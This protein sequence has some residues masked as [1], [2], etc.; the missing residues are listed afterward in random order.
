[1]PCPLPTVRASLGASSLT[2]LT[3]AL[4]LGGCL[5]DPQAK[6]CAE[7]PPGS[8]GCPADGGPLA[9]AAQDTADGGPDAA[10]DAAPDDD[11]GPADAAPG[12]MGGDDMAG[13]DMAG[14]DMGGGE[15]APGTDRPC[16]SDEGACVAGRQYCGPDGRYAECVGQT[17]PADEAC[18]GLDD[19]CD[20]TTDEG[21]D[22]VDGSTQPCGSDVGACMPGEQTCVGGAWSACEGAVDGSE[23]ICDAADNDCDGTA[24]EVPAVV[25]MRPC[26][27]GTG[28]CAA[29]GVLVCAPGTIGAPSCSAVEGAP[30]AESCNGQDDDC[31]EATDEDI[32]SRS[33]RLLAGEEVETVP[34]AIAP[35]GEFHGVA[36]IDDG[37]VFFGLALGDEWEAGPVEVGGYDGGDSGG[38]YLALSRTADGFRIAVSSW[39]VGSGSLNVFHLSPGGENLRRQSIWNSQSDG[40]DIAHRDGFGY[41]IAFE[42][43][44]GGAANTRDIAIDVV[45]DDVARMTTRYTVPGD[46][47]H[48]RQPSVAWA[49]DD[50]AVAAINSDPRN[51]SG[52]LQLSVFSGLGGVPRTTVVERSGSARNPSLIWLPQHQ[53]LALA[54]DT[55]GDV[56]DNRVVR[57]AIVDLQGNVEATFE[58][59]DAPAIHPALMARINGRTPADTLALAVR[60]AQAESFT[61]E[62]AWLTFDDGRWSLSPTVTRVANEQGTGSGPSA[63]RADEYA[64][65]YARD[66]G[67]G[68]Q[69]VFSTVDACPERP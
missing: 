1:M 48:L 42:E 68:A 65:A 49:G 17:E 11:G 33:S 58:L 63:A 34:V 10:P 41:A 8:A 6:T 40:I 21:C 37:R 44:S 14:G 66:D 47:A 36:W 24:D 55:V 5:G 38:A 56:R 30:V 51:D 62:M 60:R 52:N 54:W 18:N 4:L 64:V 23:E 13:G 67:R 45:P 39:D 20:G 3:A 43:D 57:V 35:F 26:S 61:I 32:A 12:D 29:S 22:C 7:L 46:R 50:L 53:R 59:P 16:G 27:V 69:M 25:E 31:D 28:R 15:C 9:D 2:A 19:D